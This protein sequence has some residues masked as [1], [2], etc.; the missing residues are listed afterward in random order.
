M[1]GNLQVIVSTG[2]SDHGIKIPLW[3]RE[4]V[5]WK[6]SL[7]HLSAK[8]GC[9]EEPGS[10]LSGSLWV[11]GKGK[12][13]WEYYLSCLPAFWSLQLWVEERLP[14][15]QSADYG[16]NL[17]TVQ[18]FMKKNQVSLTSPVHLS[19]LVP[20]WPPGGQPSSAVQKAGDSRLLLLM[21]AF[22]PLTS[23]EVAMQKGQ[24]LKRLQ[25]GF[26]EDH[27]GRKHH[28]TWEFYLRIWKH[29]TLLGSNECLA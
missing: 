14:L 27:R 24:C 13:V 3:E 26:W 19:L 11:F 5:I 10:A 17:Q 21:V 29:Q 16:S 18:L 15:A 2:Q 6:P 7:K 23:W 22:S 25:S 1:N 9:W 20:A 4:Q 8:W 28:V 12:A